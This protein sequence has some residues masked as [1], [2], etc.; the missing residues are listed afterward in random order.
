MNPAL[1]KCACY[2]CRRA[3][4]PANAITLNGKDNWYYCNK[5]WPHIK[6]YFAHSFLKGPMEV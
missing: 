3:P 2:K 5:C 6:D 1:T 4:N